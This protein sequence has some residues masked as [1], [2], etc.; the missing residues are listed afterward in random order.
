MFRTATPPATAFAQLAALHVLPPLAFISEG[1]DHLAQLELLAL[2]ARLQPG[3]IHDARPRA[4]ACSSWVA[5]T[6]AARHTVEADGVAGGPPVEVGLGVRSAPPHRRP[7]PVDP[8]ATF[9]VPE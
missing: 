1:D 9:A 7:L 2:A 6:L 3:A 4:P 5:F 8:S